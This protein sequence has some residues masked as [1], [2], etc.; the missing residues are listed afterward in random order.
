[1]FEKC[2]LRVQAVLGL[3]PRSGALSVQDVLGDLLARMRREAVKHD[4]VVAASIR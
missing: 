2:L 4:G 3:V 1:M